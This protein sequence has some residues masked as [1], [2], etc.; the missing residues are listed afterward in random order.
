VCVG[1]GG[2][3]R[4]SGGTAEGG[5]EYECTREEVDESRR[6]KQKNKGR[7]CCSVPRHLLAL[8]HFSFHTVIVFPSTVKTV[9]MP[10][11]CI[12]RGGHTDALQ[13][14]S[15]SLLCGYKTWIT[16]N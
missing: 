14:K 3:L 8:L 16:W 5:C 10:G 15:Y 12:W 6:K 11:V 9:C 13:C 4:P 2:G 7:K 1:A